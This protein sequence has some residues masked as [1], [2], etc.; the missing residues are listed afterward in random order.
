MLIS[1]PGFAQLTTAAAVAAP[2]A[3]G[4][5]VGQDIDETAMVLEPES[6]R[7][8]LL[9]AAEPPY[10]A[11]ADIRMDLCPAGHNQAKR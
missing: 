6:R 3:V 5:Q 11:L 1:V 4:A 9:A 2:Q 7:L 10:S 8:Q